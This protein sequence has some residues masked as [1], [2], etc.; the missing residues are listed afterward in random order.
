MY[1]IKRIENKAQIETCERFDV[2]N[3][4]WNSSREPKTYGWL[5]YIEG[6]GLYVKFVCE[7]S[8]PLRNYKNHRDPV[9]LDSTVEV[10]LAFL[11]DGEELSNDCMYTNFEFNSNGAL[12]ANYGEGRTGR[13]SITD[14]QFAL[15]DCKAEIHEDYWTA[16][17]TI[18][19]SYLYQICDFDAFK[20]GKQF[21]C[22]FYKIG[23]TKEIVH[24]G[25]YSPI[26]SPA[27]NFHMPICF[28]PIAIEK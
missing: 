16:S 28:A 27:P 26:D 4:M 6:T 23:E 2:S 9:Y 24:F 20:A 3:F 7:E 8:D 15:A 13:Q 12:L 17:V 1:K 10:F 22:N 21:Y 5:G 11:K 19:E 14:E 18:P 25:A